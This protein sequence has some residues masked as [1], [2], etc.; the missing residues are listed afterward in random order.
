MRQKGLY[1][2]TSIV[3]A[4]LIGT[5]FELYRRGPSNMPSLAAASY[6]PL[7][8]Q[9]FV[10]APGRVEPISE[11]IEIGA[12]IIGKLKAILVEEGSHVQAGQ[13]LAIIENSDYEAQSVSAEARLSQAD[14][15]LRRV[16]N[17]AR[18]QERRE[19]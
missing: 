17:G 15:E 12:E 6:A 4:A 8:P 16:I 18:S 7:Q 5:T 19:A 10:T 3:I 9:S 13:T 1:T 11:E 2:F 14:A